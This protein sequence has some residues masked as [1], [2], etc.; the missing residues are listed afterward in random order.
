MRDYLNRER[1]RNQDNTS[2]QEY[3]CGGYALGTYSWYLPYYDFE[4]REEQ[5]TDLISR[6]F[7]EYQ[8]Y[9]QLLSLDTKQMLSDF[10]ER[11]RVIKNESDLL[12]TETLIAYRIFVEFNFYNGK[13]FYEDSDFHFRVKRGDR[14]FEKNGDDLI[15]TVEDMSLFVPWIAQCGEYDSEVVLLAL[16]N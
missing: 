2:L 16:K 9:R 15:H 5:V 3:N 14:W 13:L 10:K 7:N 8:I 1:K 4:T 6:G 12:D 11:L